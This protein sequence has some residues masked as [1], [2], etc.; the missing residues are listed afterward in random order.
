MRMHW[1]VVGLGWI[2][3]G[4]VLSGGCG[5]QRTADFDPEGV[6]GELA[7]CAFSVT[8]NTYDGPNFW[9]T[10]TVKNGGPSATGYSVEFDV[11][12]GVHCTNDAVPSGATLSPLSGSGSSAATKSNHCKFTWA[13]AKLA[14]GASTTFNYSTDAS[15]FKSASKV[16]VTSKSC[17][18]G[19]TTTGGST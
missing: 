19:G 4:C 12:S 8:N 15:N 2:G 11:P 13:S 6:E 9:G 16:V 3:L 1:I 5:A 14:S 10:I 7:A 18:S 17:G